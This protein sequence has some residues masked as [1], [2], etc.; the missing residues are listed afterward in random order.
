MARRRY[1]RFDSLVWEVHD[2]PVSM[3]LGPCA[4]MEHAECPR[5]YRG[6]SG[7]F[8]CDCACHAADPAASPDS[9]SESEAPRSPA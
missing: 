7:P 6:L 1:A 9:P 5:L 2:T 3:T 4:R 8:A